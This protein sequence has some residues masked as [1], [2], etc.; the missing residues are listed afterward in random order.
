M[1]TVAEPPLSMVLG[2]PPLGRHGPTWATTCN[3]F[4]SRWYIQPSSCYVRFGRTCTIVLLAK[5]WLC[6]CG[7]VNRIRAFFPDFGKLNSF[8]AGLCSTEARRLKPLEMTILPSMNASHGKQLSPAFENTGLSGVI[9]FQWNQV[10]NISL[11]L[12]ESCGAGRL[13]S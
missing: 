2:Q 11:F 6:W 1:Q 8:Y 12:T 3:D 5:S 7:L 4:G 10:L 13:P 9:Q